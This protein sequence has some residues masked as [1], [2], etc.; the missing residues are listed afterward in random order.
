MLYNFCS[1]SGCTDGGY[2]YAE[3]VLD[4]KG[5]LYGTTSQGGKSNDG[6]VFKVTPSGEETVL[7][8]FCS[9]GGCR[10]G[11][12]PTAGLV[13]DAKG[14]LYGTTYVG[15]AHNQGTVFKLKP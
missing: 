15:G 12:D 4:A 9:E 7:H 13:F 2:P 8:N 3:L 11:A 10:D 6:I 1:Q 5:N 14:N